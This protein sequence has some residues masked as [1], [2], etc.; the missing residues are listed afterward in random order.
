MNGD[1]NYQLPH[2]L[3]MANVEEVTEEL[4]ELLKIY[5]DGEFI[6]DGSN[7]QNID[8][9]GIQ[10]LLAVHKTLV[11]GGKGFQ[12]INQSNTLQRLLK[13]SGAHRIILEGS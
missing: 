8:A 7:L 9:A 1:Y 2:E 5:E 4:R 10:V 11:L 12:L 6:V 13:L 3:T